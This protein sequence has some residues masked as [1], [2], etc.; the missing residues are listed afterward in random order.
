MPS[1]IR[2][3]TICAAVLCALIIL[4]TLRAGAAEE[5][6]NGVWKYAPPQASINGEFNNED[7]VGLAAVARRLP[8]LSNPVAGNIATENQMGANARRASHARVTPR[9]PTRKNL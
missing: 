9:A 6:S 4:T 7:A 2:P 5:P 8:S 1:G 3:R